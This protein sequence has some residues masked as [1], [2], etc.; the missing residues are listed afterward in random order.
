MLPHSS[1]T[2]LSV[3]SSVCT[4]DC[5]YIYISDMDCC[6]PVTMEDRV[7]DGGAGGGGMRHNANT[8]TLRSHPQPGPGAAYFVRHI[9]HVPGLLVG[10]SINT[11]NPSPAL[12]C[13]PAQEVV[14]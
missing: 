7:T 8:V 2:T 9:L 4:W 13:R 11:D 5:L 1:A 10:L 3:D 14:F 12:I 6:F